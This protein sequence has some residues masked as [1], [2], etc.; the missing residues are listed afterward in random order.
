MQYHGEKANVASYRYI[1]LA[2]IARQLG[3]RGQCDAAGMLPCWVGMSR[4]PPRGHGMGMW[5]TWDG[6]G[7]G[8]MELELKWVWAA[9]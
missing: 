8:W 5:E 9:V 7:G 3:R 4:A 1:F 2:R 6:M